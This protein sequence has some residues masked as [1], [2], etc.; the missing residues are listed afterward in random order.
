V[1]LD[2]DE[3]TNALRLTSEARHEIAR[4]ALSLARRSF[5]LEQQRETF[6]SRL[7]TPRESVRQ[8]S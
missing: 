6:W 7:G 8:A 4:N 3:L 2:P 1:S 5:S